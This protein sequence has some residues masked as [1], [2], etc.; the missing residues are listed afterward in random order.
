MILIRLIGLTRFLFGASLRGN[1]LIIICIFVLV[2]CS[3]SDKSDKKNPSVNS[4]KDSSINK[5]DKDINIPAYLFYRWIAKPIIRKVVY[6]PG[7]PL[8]EIPNYISFEN[9]IISQNP[10]TNP[11][12][13]SKYYVN[14]STPFEFYIYIELTDRK[15]K[16]IEFNKCVLLLH[17]EEINLF[18]T[19]R[20]NLKLSEWKEWNEII[21]SEIGPYEGDFLNGNKFIVNNTDE[22]YF[23]GF[24]LGFKELFF[25]YL[26]N[27]EIKIQYEV[28][29]TDDTNNTKK[30]TIEIPF[31]RSITD[32]QG[33]EISIEEWEK[34]K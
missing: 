3:V 6:N 4:D 13:F 14:Y 26:A 11:V 32:R 16:E 9:K 34:Y 12:S 15:I 29:I 22:Y 5:S 27:E 18:D 24:T 23:S 30:Q 8:F 25:D 31:K 19:K 1:V 7:K 20:E 17:N 2:S 21:M 28:A 10:T 33:N